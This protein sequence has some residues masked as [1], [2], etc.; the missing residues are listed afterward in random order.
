TANGKI[1]PLELEKI[2]YMVISDRHVLEELERIYPGSIEECE[3]YRH[4]DGELITANID[5]LSN[6]LYKR[7]L[8]IYVASKKAEYQELQKRLPVM[9]LEFLGKF[10]SIVRKHDLAV[11][12]GYIKKIVA[13]IPVVVGDNIINHT[14]CEAVGYFD[15]NA[16]TIVMTTMMPGDMNLSADN[17]SYL[18]ESLFHTY[19]HELLHAISGQDIMGHTDEEDSSLE[20]H[21]I[22]RL[23]LSIINRFGWLNEAITEETT[24]EIL[25]TEQGIYSEERDLVQLIIENSHGHIPFELLQNAYFE[26]HRK[27]SELTYLPK[28]IQ[29]FNKAYG[30]GFLVKLDNVIREHGIEAGIE[31]ITEA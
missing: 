7:I 31:F 10:L 26:H 3:G 1:N 11:S 30:V 9:K 19:A 27:D 24:C 16:N 15:S 6:A 25:Q 28:L 17:D 18:E 22:Q 5:K 4:I 20:Y 21:D 2:L 14:G 29:A 13:E 23:G 8:E 12:E